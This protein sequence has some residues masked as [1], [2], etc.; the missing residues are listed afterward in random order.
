MENWFTKKQFEDLFPYANIGWGPHICFPY[1]YESFIIAARYF[2]NFGTSSPHNQLTPTNNTR[3]DLATFFAHAIQETGLNDIS[4][5]SRLF[6]ETK[7]CGFCC[8]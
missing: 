3:R 7:N 4:L 2:P 5:Y 8:S 6:L 1:S